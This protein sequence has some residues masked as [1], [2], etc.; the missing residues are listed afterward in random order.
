M[1]YKEIVKQFKM[2]NERYKQELEELKNSATYSESN[3]VQ[4]VS[5]LREVITDIDFILSKANNKDK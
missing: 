2:L 3:K 1:E 5:V 4:T